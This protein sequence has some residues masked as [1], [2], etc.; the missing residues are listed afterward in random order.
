[1]T[2][3]LKLQPEYFEYIKSGTKE[4]EIR[5]NDEKRKLIKIGDIIEFK[6]EPKLDEKMYLKVDDLIYFSDFQELFNSIDIKYLASVNTSKNVL[7]KDLNKFYPIEK[8]NEY[9]VVAIKLNKLKEE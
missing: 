8:Q 1:M 2:H 7:L 9:G 3:T 4:Y 5:L 6:K